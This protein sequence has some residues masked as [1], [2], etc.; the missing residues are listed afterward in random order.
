[1]SRKVS[2]KHR[3]EL[4][5]NYALKDEPKIIELI[6]EVYDNVENNLP[7]YPETIKAIIDI[8]QRYNSRLFK[9]AAWKGN[10]AINKCVVKALKIVKELKSKKNASFG[11]SF[12]YKEI[13][14]FDGVKSTYNT[15]INEQS[16]IKDMIIEFI[17][18]D[19]TDASRLRVQLCLF[20]IN[21]CNVHKIK[22]KDFSRYKREAIVGIVLESIGVEVL[23]KS[24]KKELTVAKYSNIISPSY[25]KAIAELSNA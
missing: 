9:V 20:V 1:M 13:F 25:K 5:I 4:K 19:K 21:Y 12:I 14:E 15:V 18:V 17:N 8:I 3:G 22:L 11:F 2:Y 23:N 16:L 6:N 24:Q 10:K 7:T